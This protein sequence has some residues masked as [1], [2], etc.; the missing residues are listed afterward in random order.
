MGP[1][2]SSDYDFKEAYMNHQDTTKLNKLL[3]ITK[4]RFSAN[5]QEN[6]IDSFLSL[7]APQQ[8]VVNPDLVQA[9]RQ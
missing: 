2:V 1:V 3:T 4:K 5:E 9:L 8:M 6:E 7:A